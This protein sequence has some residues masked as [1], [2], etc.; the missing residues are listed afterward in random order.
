MSQSDQPIEALLAEERVFPPPA[1]Y[2][3]SANLTDSAIYERAAKD[4]EA[5]WAEAAENLEWI[6]KWDRVLDWDPP[7]AQWFVGG[8]INVSVN[9]LDRHVRGWR[10]NKAAFIWEGEPGE[11]RVLT[12]ADL[13]REVNIFANAMKRLGVKKGDRV[14]IYMPMIPELPIALLACA[15]IGA[16]HSVV[17]GGFSSE[18]LRDRINDAQ[19]RLVITADGSYRRGQIVPL[20][21][22]VDAA[23]KDCPCVEKVV[24]VRRVGEV[25]PVTVEEGRDIWWHRAVER[26]PAYCEPEPMDSEDPLFILYTSGTTAKPKGI[27]HTTAGYLLG[28]SLTHKWVFD[29]KEEDVYWCSA[30]IGWVT[31]H[32]Y[33]VY[34]PLAN[35]TTGVLYEGSPDWPDKDRWWAMVAKY[36]VN[37]F[38]TA[39]TAIRAV[40]KWG[41]AFPAKHDLS[42]LRLLGTVGEPIN[43]E[44]WMWYHEKIGKGRCPIVDTWW[45]TETGS[46]MISPLP[47][48]TTTKP[49][50]ATFPLPGIKADVVDEA[51]NSVPLGGGGYLVLKSPWPSMARTIYGDPERYEETYWRRFGKNVYFAGDGCKRDEDGYFWLLGRV[52]D[53]MNISGHRLSTMEVESALVD[54]QE[55]AE[56]AVIGKK[57]EI[58]G[59]AIAAFVTLKEGAEGGA[60]KVDELKRHVVRK[61][62]PIARPANVYFTAELPKTRSGKI[63]RRLLRDIAEGRAL[64]DTTTLADASVVARLKSQY[65]ES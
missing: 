17:F 41:E 6:K 58:K 40:M 51:G 25:A 47:G 19:S 13:Y 2:C 65:E 33:I 46:I 18:S 36:G 30:D 32:S 52:D 27:L 39:P 48:L 43:P 12:F 53:V 14:T 3:R 1:E 29:V 15:R 20:K 11:E 9:C 26:V 7:I 23:L 10:R 56:A 44:A 59:E 49:G 54:H 35:G 45:Q 42:S 8:K 16:P 22:N 37:I 63:M 24:M 62:G 55:V 28:A 57:D 64:G 60:G 34:G 4:P 5:Y 61:I 31:G 21:R 50:S 38:Y